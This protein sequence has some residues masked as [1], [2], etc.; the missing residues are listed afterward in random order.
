MLRIGW[1]GRLD[2][3]FFALKLTDLGGYLGVTKKAIDF[4]KE[5]NDDDLWEDLLKYSMDKPCKYFDRAPALSY[6][7]TVRALATAI[8]RA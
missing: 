5:Q 4:A 3:I 7:V 2:Q 6:S 1:P 8:I